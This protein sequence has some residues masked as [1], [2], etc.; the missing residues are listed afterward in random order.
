MIELFR[1]LSFALNKKREKY[2][3]LVMRV[4]YKLDASLFNRPFSFI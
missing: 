4:E 2:F 1:A 3:I